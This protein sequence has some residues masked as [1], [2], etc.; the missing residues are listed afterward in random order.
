MKG[1]FD[2]L[3]DVGN[4]E[5]RKVK[6]Y[7]A[8]ALEV[9]TCKVSDQPE[10]YEYETAI[11]HREYNDYKWIIV[12]MYKTKSKSISGHLK[13]VKVMTA[14]KLP[15]KIV[16]VSDIGFTKMMDILQKEGESWRTK[17]KGGE[18]N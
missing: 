8:G 11:R 1:M 12:E 5:E 15:E 18:M 9:D 14:K 16:D 2:F 13:W 3:L 7:E 4:Y 10:P 17:K 6:N